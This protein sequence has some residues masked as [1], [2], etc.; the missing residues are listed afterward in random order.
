VAN[1]SSGLDVLL[2]ASH[3]DGWERWVEGLLKEG[4]REEGGF[5]EVDENWL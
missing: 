3:I 1:G 2:A 4:R 5:N